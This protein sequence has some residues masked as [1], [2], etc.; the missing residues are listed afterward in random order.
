[1]TRFGTYSIP[2]YISNETIQASIEDMGFGEI[3][4]I[5]RKP[6]LNW[7]AGILDIVIITMTSWTSKGEQFRDQLKY[8]VSVTPSC[9]CYPW[10]FVLVE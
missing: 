2:V 1:M 8:G 4:S 7:G 9:D 6:N 5:D 10:K 3:E